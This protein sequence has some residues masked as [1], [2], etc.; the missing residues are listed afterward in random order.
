MAQLN[1]EPQLP[2]SSSHETFTCSMCGLEKTADEFPKD[3]KRNNGIGSNCHECRKVVNAK[4]RK[5]HHD[6]ILAKQRE[7]R[8]LHPEYNRSAYN[9]WRIA[10]LERAREQARKS[11]K[12]YYWKNQ[13]QRKEYSRQYAK[14]NPDKVKQTRQNWKRNHLEAYREGERRRS[15]RW[16]ANHPER[17]KEVTA[18]YKRSH[19]QT[20]KIAWQNW[21]ARKKKNG[22]T[23]KTKE[24]IELCEKYDNKCVKCGER[25]KLTVDHV[26][27]VSLGGR[28]DIS[29][30]QPLCA[31]CNREKHATIADYRPDA[32]ESRR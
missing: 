24:W 1:G 13:E 5:K 14:T 16:R 3:K 19:P 20:S 31:K 29:N 17:E 18:K 11:T 2:H 15:K 32:P 27:P 28:N 26:I 6:K 21:R 9:K 12:K 10:N 22:G 7:H 4:Y 23:F 8:R 30:I 25:K